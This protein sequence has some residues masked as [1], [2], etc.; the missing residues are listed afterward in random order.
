LA[1]LPETP[2]VEARLMRY[3]VAAAQPRS[4]QQAY[5]ALAEQFGL[6]W[7]TRTRQMP[8]QSEVH[9]NNRVRTAMKN[10]VEKGYSESPIRDHWV[11]TK[12]GCDRIQFFDSLKGKVKI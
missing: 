9:W 12:A 8:N 11:A 1:D 10:L 7:S 5:R 2:E 4:A 3:L 6:D